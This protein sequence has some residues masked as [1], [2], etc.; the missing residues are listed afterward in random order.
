MPDT[1]VV[2]SDEARSDGSRGLKSQYRGYGDRLTEKAR[3]GESH[4]LKS[5]YRRRGD[6]PLGLI[7]V[8]QVRVELWAEESIPR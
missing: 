5:Q 8:A 1:E 2:V 6:W 4:G 7:E 3:S